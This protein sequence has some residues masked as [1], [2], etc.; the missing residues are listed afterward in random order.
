VNP[1]NPT[2]ER[3]ANR[4]G[5]AFLL[6][7]DSFLAECPDRFVYPHFL[8][9][10][11]RWRVSVAGLV[12][13][14]FD[15]GRLSEASYRRAFMFLNQN[16][17]RRHEQNEPEPEPPHMLRRALSLVA[18]DLPLDQ[19]A[20]ALGLAASDLTDLLGGTESPP[21]TSGAPSPQPV[22]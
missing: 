1:A 16:D 9:L 12:K 4:F 20:N 13:R 11:R 8:E 19:V 6:P 7:R 15:L 18:E 2:A 14:A 22:R 10:K 21:A 5:S 17:L 3:E